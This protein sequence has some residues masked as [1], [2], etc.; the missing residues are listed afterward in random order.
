MTW[1]DRFEFRLLR[2]LHQKVSSDLSEDQRDRVL[3]LIL[4][5]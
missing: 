2:V 3:S 5:L 4:S 1:E